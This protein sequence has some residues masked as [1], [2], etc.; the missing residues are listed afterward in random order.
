M[1]SA[2]GLGHEDGPDHH[3]SSMAS[4]LPLELRRGEVAFQVRQPAFE[5][6]LSR[7]LEQ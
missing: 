3:M 2:M 7:G 1:P 5:R 4:A 6:F